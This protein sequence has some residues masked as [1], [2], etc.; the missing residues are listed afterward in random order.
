MCLHV[1]NLHARGV[2]AQ[3]CGWM[4][5]RRPAGARHRSVQIK[6]VLHVTRGVV[7]R[8]VERFEVVIVV[9]HL[10]ALEDLEPHGPE[11]RL[12][13][14]ADQGEG[15]TPSERRLASRQ[16][17]VHAPGRPGRRLQRL[18]P[19]RERLLDRAFQR[20]GGLAERGSVR[21]GCAGHRLHQRRQCALF[22]PE[23]PVP[24]RLQ[25]LIADHP[26]QIGL[27]R[28]AD[29]VDVGRG[30]HGLGPSTGSSDV[31]SED[32]AGRAPGYRE[33]E[34]TGET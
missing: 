4:R 20:V 16:G 11:D 5:G 19:V 33:Q 15:V 7:R 27:E 21:G 29:G 1:T 8:H 23:I 6:R 32:I 12:D 34:K 10:R 25:V 28:G 9:F 26:L 17:D 24:H 31:R 2:R 30:G 22:S 14:L 18:P 13:L 3:Q